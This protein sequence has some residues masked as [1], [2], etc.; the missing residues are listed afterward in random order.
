MRR[1]FVRSFR[2]VKFSHYFYFFLLNI[3]SSLFVLFGVEARMYPWERFRTTRNSKFGKCS[4]ED[5]LCMGIPV[6]F[7]QYVIVFYVI[8]LSSTI[9]HLG[10]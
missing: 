3:C 7:P 2:S 4:K 8:I 10:D 1:L 5:F 6:V 9:H